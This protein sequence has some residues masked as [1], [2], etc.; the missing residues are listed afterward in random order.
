[1]E[2]QSLVIDD[3]EL[4]L[5]VVKTITSVS[6]MQHCF[7]RIDGDSF[8]ASMLL[9]ADSLK[10]HVVKFLTN[11][12][13]NEEF[14]KLL[15]KSPNSKV[16]VLKHVM[17]CGSIIFGKFCSEQVKESN[18]SPWEKKLEIH[19]KVSIMCDACVC[20]NPIVCN[21]ISD[22]LNYK[23]YYSHHGLKQFFVNLAA[24]AYYE[25]YKGEYSEETFTEHMDVA[26]RVYFQRLNK[27][28]HALRNGYEEDNEMVNLVKSVGEHHPQC[29]LECLAIMGRHAISD[30]H[31]RMQHY[32]RE[33][34]PEKK[35]GEYF[36][37]VAK[38]MS[39][40]Y[41]ETFMVRNYLDH[42]CNKPKLLQLRNLGTGPLFDVNT[43]ETM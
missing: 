43:G 36:E 3:P 32:N 34:V 39:C 10:K 24:E 17:E 4:K 19:N 27:G 6:L 9:L 13:D 11:D 21:S 25:A 28:W 41:D 30:H 12:S 16:A 33:P 8:A 26:G 35:T 20:T 2:Q 29:V 38:A 14:C 15:V 42:C 5:F 23:N 7:P 40:Y 18:V 37:F 22:A 1:M 31:T